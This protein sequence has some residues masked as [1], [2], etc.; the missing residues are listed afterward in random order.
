[1]RVTLA[2]IIGILILGVPSLV[3]SEPIPNQV[4]KCVAYIVKPNKDADANT[5][6][7]TAFFV[8]YQYAEVPDKKYIFLV[9]ARHVLYDDEGKRHKKLLIRLNNKSTGRAK[10]FDILKKNAWFEH[11]K[12]PKAVDIVVQPLLPREADFLYISSSD[13][14]T[15]KLLTNRKIGIGDELF[16]TGL[17]SYHSGRDKIAPI[18]R[19]GRLALVSSEKTVDQKYYHFID[20]GNIPG[21]SGSPLFLWAT[22]TRVP[23]QIVAGSRIFGLY[24][25]V[26]G[27]LEYQKSLRAVAPRK[28]SGKQLILLDARSG[29]VTAVVPVKFLIEILEGSHIRNAIGIIKQN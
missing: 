6:V 4:R 26:S 29:G 22:A 15:E 24:G 9:T 5:P 23:G 25:V 16:Y 13:F 2:F 28:T 11:Q 17:L 3:L 7:G 19:F 14:V 8:G 1:M 20:A 12:E 18:V 27:V 21:H 10:D